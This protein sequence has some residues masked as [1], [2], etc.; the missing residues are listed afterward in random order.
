M[1]RALFALFTLLMLALAMSP[2]VLAETA[3][4]PAAGQAAPPVNIDR[5]QPLVP[6]RH[7]AGTLPATPMAC[8]TRQAPAMAR[9]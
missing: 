2:P 4:A 6:P 7:P 8:S 3:G 9:R 5:R 1:I